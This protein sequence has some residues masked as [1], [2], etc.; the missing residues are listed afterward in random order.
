MVAIER[1]E[2]S[3]LL[4]K[5][6]ILPLNYVA[7]YGQDS[8]NRT[9]D[10]C[11]Q[12]IR[13]TIKLYPDM[14]GKIGIEPTQPY[15]NRFTVCPNSP[16]L[17]FPLI[18]MVAVTRIELVSIGYQPI[19]LPLNYT[20]IWKK[21]GELNPKQRFCRPHSQPYENTLYTKYLHNEKDKLW[22]SL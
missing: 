13:F 1:I 12:N 18:E 21:V 4:C 10:L 3:T 14:V 8:R 17:A 11:S 16:T 20:A 19:V 15:D 5:S 22:K 9:Y 6:S 2:L 7:I